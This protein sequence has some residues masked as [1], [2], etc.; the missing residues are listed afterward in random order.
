MLHWE[1][2]VT[3]AALES[4]GVS[5]AEVSMRTTRYHAVAQLLAA[6]EAMIDIEGLRARELVALE[7]LGIG[8]GSTKYLDLRSAVG[9]LA[10]GDRGFI[11]F[12]YV[13]VYC[14]CAR[15]PF[16]RTFM[17]AMDGDFR[18]AV[19]F[20]TFLRTIA[21]FCSFNHDMI[22]YFVFD[23][24]LR[25]YES[26]DGHVYNGAR[27]QWTGEYSAADINWDRLISIRPVTQLLYELNPPPTDP[28]LQH[29]WAAYAA[30]KQVRSLADR[31]HRIRLSHLYHALVC[32]FPHTLTPLYALQQQLQSEFLGV[33]WWLD[34]D[35]TFVEA[36]AFVAGKQ[37]AMDD[38]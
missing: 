14:G 6:R 34:R 16:L 11:P 23:V 3:R 2:S 37:K 28:A 38:M 35:R 27:A 30:L 10:M 1:E 24:L 26:R 9:K 7:Y 15:L 20:V 18:G 8:N 5:L 19:D 29:T 13:F 25:Q 12:S 32:Q 31:Q 17:Q 21:T 4:E 33:S 36:R 22:L